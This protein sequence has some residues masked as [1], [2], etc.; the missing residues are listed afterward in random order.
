MNQEPLCHYLAWDSDF[1]GYRIARLSGGRV[2][3]ERMV[4]VMQWCQ[5]ETIDCLYFLAE[6]DDQESVRVAENH[7]FR[8]VDVRLTLEKSA[9]SQSSAP[10][11]AI[12]FVVPADIPALRQLARTS[13]RDSRFYYDPHFSEVQCAALY[14]TW[15]EK[16]CQGYAEAVLV[17]GPVAQPVG[18]LSCHLLPSGESSIGLI[19]I[20]ATAQGQ[21]LGQRLVHAAV[22]WVAA[23]GPS[24]ISV[25][26]QGRNLRAQRLYQRCG[27]LPR[28]L[29]L[30]Y[31]WWS[32]TFQPTSGNESP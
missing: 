30:W 8:L 10:D 32:P 22:A 14:D 13:H 5:E 6:S 17:A 26:T 16:S 20:G 9:L 24:T 25:V 2:S 23:Q 11:D 19:A 3:Q 1:F 29:Q 12:R 28:S 4:A 15:I 31:H 18:Y 7:R 27:F 21:G